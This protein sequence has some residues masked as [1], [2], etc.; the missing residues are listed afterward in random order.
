M[1]CTVRDL[2]VFDEELGAGR[3]L[4]LSGWVLDHRYMAHHFEPVFAERAGW[5]RLYVGSPRQRTHDARQGR[6]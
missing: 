6:T 4:L 1:R 5:R 3:P 2:T